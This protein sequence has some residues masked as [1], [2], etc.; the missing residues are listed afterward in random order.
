MVPA[1][2]YLVV[3]VPLGDFAIVL[4]SDRFGLR[5]AWTVDF[6]CELRRELG[7][8]CFDLKACLENRSL[9]EFRKEVGPSSELIRDKLGYNQAKADSLSVHLL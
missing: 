8:I 7:L 3:L 9:M 4:C 6:R 1:S 2:L 5:G